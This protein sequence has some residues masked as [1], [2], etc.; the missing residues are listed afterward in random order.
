MAATLVGT[1]PSTASAQ[2]LTKVSAGD[3]QQTEVK[4]ESVKPK[5]TK[6]PTLRFLR[7]NRDFIRARLDLIKQR[8]LEQGAKAGEMD[9]RF[10]RYQ[11][12]MSDI[13]ASEDSVLAAEGRQNRLALMEN[14]QELG[15][16]EEQLDL[17]EQL[18]SD[19]RTRLS[20]L[21]EDFTGEQR[22]ALLVLLSGYP[23]GVTPTQIELTVEDGTTIKIPFTTAQ[24]QAL[25]DGGLAQIYYGFVEPRKQ[26]LEVKVL[27][28][29][30]PE[31]RSG[32]LTLNPP[33]DRLSF[34]KLDISRL[35]AAGPGGSMRATTW[36]HQADVL[37]SSRGD[38]TP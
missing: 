31:G 38:I 34:L 1:V 28:A 10:L 20:M 36:L 25:V 15:T 29:Q 21:Q 5:Q 27:S 24:E 18:L 33:R 9:P 11:Q 13:L 8:A 4:V 14:I 26:V 32:Y 22:T 30:W 37:T 23:A 3:I 19:Q 12:M 2:Q 7:E 16:L 17:M 6:H 35:N